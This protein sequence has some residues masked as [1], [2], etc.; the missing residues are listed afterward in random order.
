MFLNTF[1]LSINQ[2]LSPCHIGIG[3][4]LVSLFLLGILFDRNVDKAKRITQM[5]ISCM[6]FVGCLI[7][8]EIIIID[9]FGMNHFTKKEIKKRATLDN[10]EIYYLEK[11]QQDILL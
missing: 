3:D 6:I 7:F 9:C 2:L 4:T 10:Q 8:T 5:G 1:L 11:I